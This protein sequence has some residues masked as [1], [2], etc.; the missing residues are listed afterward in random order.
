MLIFASLVPRVNTSA[1]TTLTKIPPTSKIKLPN[2][3]GLLLSDFTGIPRIPTG[4]FKIPITLSKHHNFSHDFYIVP[5]MTEECI[6]GIDFMHKYGLK[7]DGQNGTSS[8]DH[9]GV[10]CKLNNSVTKQKSP[11]YEP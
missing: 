8:Y 5:D 6:L 9:D 11:Y 4:K 1:G 2:N 3:T 7:F 10:T